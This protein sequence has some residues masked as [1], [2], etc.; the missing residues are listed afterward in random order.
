MSRTACRSEVSKGHTSGVRQRTDE[1]VRK[2]N[3]ASA[4]QPA[5]AAMFSGDIGTPLV[6]TRAEWVVSLGSLYSIL[7]VLARRTR[8]LR[9][10]NR[11]FIVMPSTLKAVGSTRLWCSKRQRPA[12]LE[13][14]RG[15]APLQRAQD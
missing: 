2:I 15:V 3:T 10:T 13:C 12:I 6:A 4:G 7:R 11:Q 14:T 9:I 8:I 1:E 5:I